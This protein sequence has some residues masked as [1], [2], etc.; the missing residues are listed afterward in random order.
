MPTPSTLSQTASVTIRPFQYRDLG[1]VERLVS[2]L[3]GGFVTQNY[4]SSHDLAQQLDQVRRWYGPLKLL[5]LF[6]NP[7][8][9]FF[10]AYVADHQN[11][12]KG[13]IQVTPFNRTGSTWRIDRIAAHSL[14]HTGNG[15][16]NG[17]GSLEENGGEIKAVAAQGDRP[18][19][20]DLET[21]TPLS[22]D[23]A[24]QLLRFCLDTIW[25]ARTW[26]VEVDV[27]DAAG[28]G[29]YRK[30]GFQSLAQMTYWELSTELLD[31]L[32]QQDVS[33]PNLRPVSS[34]DAAL[35]HQLDTVSMPPLVRQVFDRHVFDFKFSLTRSAVD[36]LNRLVHHQDVVGGYV[37]EPQRKAA[38]GHFRL[39]ICQNGSSPHSAQLTVHPAYTWLYPK[40][41]SQM[42]VIAQ[43][44]PSQSLLLASS[45]YQ[46]ERENYLE[47]IGATRVQHTL[48]M[49]R[50]VWHKV[51]ETKSVSLESLQLSE[52]LQGLQPSRKPVPGRISLMDGSQ[53]KTPPRPAQSSDEAENRLAYRQSPPAPPVA[54]PRRQTPSLQ[55]PLGPHPKNSSQH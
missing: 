23:V 13:L 16:S 9:H 26:L 30:H 27:N 10:S 49:S 20:T 31:A 55:N 5:S 38:I 52:V 44:Y 1:A 8:Q 15:T 17:H 3:P 39:E 22:T 28:L 33:L 53:G 34:A 7:L 51:R 36:A 21:P 24:S 42:A 25:K 18:L 37:F 12:L 2:D 40:L 43:A 54:P 50:S 45:D 48:M 4:G 46:P 11:T 6:P 47:R 35:L 29:L 14:P 32:A 19:D 41:V